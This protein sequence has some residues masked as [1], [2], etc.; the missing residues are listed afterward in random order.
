MSVKEREWKKKLINKQI[1]MSI[2]KKRTENMTKKRPKKRREKN[3]IL[4]KYVKKK[5]EKKADISLV[6]WKEKKFDVHSL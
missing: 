6:F 1:Y 3:E 5:K 4:K 2:K